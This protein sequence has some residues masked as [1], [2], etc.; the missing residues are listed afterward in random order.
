MLLSQIDG[1]I[2]AAPI[3]QQ[4]QAQAIAAQAKQIAQRFA[5]FVGGAQTSLD[6]CIYDFRHDLDDVRD[7]V[8]GAINGAAARRVAVRIAYDRH[9]QPVMIR[10]SSASGRRRRPGAGWYRGLPSQHRRTACGGRDPPCRREAIASG[11]QIMHNKYM[12]ADADSDRTVVWM[13]SA[14]F[15]VDAR[16]AAREQHRGRVVLP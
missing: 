15:T 16:G 4:P 11:G 1:S 14:N 6:I 13:G 3:D 9:S 12:I 10:S 7:V 2:V 8:V 5:S